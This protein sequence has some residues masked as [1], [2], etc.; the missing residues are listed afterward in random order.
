MLIHPSSKHTFFGVI[1]YVRVNWKHTD[2]AH[3]FLTIY[4]NLKF[5]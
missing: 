5:S 4:E 2:A 3:C 1:I